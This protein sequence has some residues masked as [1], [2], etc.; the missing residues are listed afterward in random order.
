MTL[1]EAL[2]IIAPLLVIQAILIIVALIDLVRRDPE[3][4]KGSKWIWA[5]VILII[6][7][8]GPI[9]YFVAGRRD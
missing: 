1:Q 6:S 2:P 5:P 7:I 3:Q 8:L 4:V 9:I